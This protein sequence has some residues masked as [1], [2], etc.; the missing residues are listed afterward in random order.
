MRE[1]TRL[2]ARARGREEDVGLAGSFDLDALVDFFLLVN[3]TG[4]EDGRVT[5]QFVGR[6]AEDGRWML[7]PWDYDK[8]FLVAPAGK[9]ARKGLMSSPLFKRI[10]AVLPSFRSRVSARWRELRSGILSEASLDGWIDERAALLAPFMD[11]DYRVVPPLG[12]DGDYAAAVEAFRAEVRFR[13]SLLDRL[14]A[15]AQF[16]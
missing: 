4:N 11:E 15:T 2:I 9:I 10:A 13:L 6:R 16:D 3:F 12:H 7:L 5:N 8:T 14:L 1:L